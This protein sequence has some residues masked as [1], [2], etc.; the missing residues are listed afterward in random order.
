MKDYNDLVE[1]VLVEGKESLDRTGTGTYRIFGTNLRFNLQSG[2]PAVTTKKLAWNSVVGELLWFIQGS[3]YL[4]RLKEL[5]HGKGI[6]DKWTIWTPNYNKQ[7]KEL[8]YVD[9]YCG[10]IY[11]KQWRNFGGVDQLAEVI[12]RIKNNPTDRRLLVSAWNPEELHKMILPPCHY[13]FQFFVEDGKLSLMWNQRSVDCFLGLPFNIASYALL[14][15]IVA[16]VCSLDVGELIFVGGDT[17]VYKDH[18]DK[19]LMQVSREP[20]NLPTLK[21]PKFKSLKELESFTAQDFE[22]ENYQHHPAIKA[23]MSA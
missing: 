6:S 23:N 19:A 21:M 16:Q 10:P 1:K 13:S 8:G 11:G 15:H 9:G 20:Y 4:D 14:C 5:T 2:F 7:G 3:T 18:V 17:H 22:L 12:E